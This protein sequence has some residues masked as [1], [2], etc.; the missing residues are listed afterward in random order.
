MQMFLFVLMLVFGK[1][2]EIYLLLQ[3]RWSN[4]TNVCIVKVTVCLWELKM[5][6]GWSIEFTCSGRTQT[7]LC[8]C[9]KQVFL[10]EQKIELHI[11]VQYEKVIFGELSEKVHF[12]L[13]LRQ[14]NPIMWHN[15]FLYNVSCPSRKICCCF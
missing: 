3:L 4:N 7:P 6:N 9:S 10:S 11:S 13:H 1:Y 14:N 15:E 8:L 5:G 12:L 2:H